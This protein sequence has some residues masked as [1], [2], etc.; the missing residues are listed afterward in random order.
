MK[1][2]NE[3]RFQLPRNPINLRWAFYVQWNSIG[4]MKAHIH[5]NQYL[6]FIFVSILIE[7]K[8]ECDGL[9]IVHQIEKQIGFH[10]WMMAINN[11]EQWIIMKSFKSFI[12][13]EYTQYDVLNTYTLN[14]PHWNLEPGT[15][16]RIIYRWENLWFR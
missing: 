1:R 13:D 2:K 10:N 14:K 15:W 8:I 16:S 12:P 4:R 9:H 7:R 3:N 6:M 5:M 11:N